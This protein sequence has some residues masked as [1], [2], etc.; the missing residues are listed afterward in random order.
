MTGVTD[1]KYIGKT[2]STSDPLLQTRFQ[3]YTYYF[4]LVFLEFS[5]TVKAAPHECVIRTGLPLT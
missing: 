3:T 1:C 4:N 5:L 2:A